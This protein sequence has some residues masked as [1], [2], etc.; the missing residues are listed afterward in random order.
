MGEPVYGMGLV[1]AVAAVTYG[2]RLAGF[3]LAG[4]RVPAALDRFLR[5]VPVAAFAALAAPDLVGGALP[6]ARLSAAVATALLV[7]LAR[8]VWVG[9]VG[10]M[11]VF[12]LLRWA[13]G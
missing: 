6:G 2:L 5:L 11:A 3:A 12:L 10:G 9:L 8:R 1:L 7:L 13:L 4:R